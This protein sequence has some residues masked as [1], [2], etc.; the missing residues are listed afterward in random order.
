LLTEDIIETLSAAHASVK[1]YFSYV[2]LDFALVDPSLEE[3]PAGWAYQFAEDL[4][5]KE[6][7]DEVVKKELKFSDKKLLQH[8][9]K[10]LAAYYEVKESDSEQ[11]YD[12]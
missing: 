4:Q 8:K 2:L 10:M 12:G 3:I 6:A 5:L 7:Y 9:Q 11:I 1:D